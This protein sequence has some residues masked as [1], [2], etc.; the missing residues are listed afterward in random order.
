MSSRYIVDL[1]RVGNF[2]DDN[3]VV[4][5]DAVTPQLL[6]AY[7][8]LVLPDEILLT[9]DSIYQEGD[10]IKAVLT[11]E[12]VDHIQG[13]F[14]NTRLCVNKGEGLHVISVDGAATFEGFEGTH[15][16]PDA[17]GIRRVDD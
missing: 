1:C 5:T 6:S 3:G 2:T 14:I 12:Y 8:T 10:F 7:K 13:L 16:D 4:Y 17:Q 9:I 15:S 11:G